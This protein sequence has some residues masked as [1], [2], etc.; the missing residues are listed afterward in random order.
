MAGGTHI[1]R[2]SCVW[3]PTYEGLC[4]YNEGTVT[5]ALRNCKGALPAGQ[6]KTLRTNSKGSSEE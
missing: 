5:K 2:P 4:G 1:L 3:V 6:R